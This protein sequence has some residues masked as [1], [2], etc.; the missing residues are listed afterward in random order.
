MNTIQEFLKKVKIL[1]RNRNI[2]QLDGTYVKINQIYRELQQNDYFNVYIKPANEVSYTYFND[3][4][5]KITKEK[6]YITK[7]EKVINEFNRFLKLCENSE[8]TKINDLYKHMNKIIEE[9]SGD[10]RGGYR[11]EEYEIYLKG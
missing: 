4:L 1:A 5:P 7:A 6:N 3:N 8:K 2:S 10:L 11:L 9:N